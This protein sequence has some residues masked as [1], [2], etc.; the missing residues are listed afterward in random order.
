[1]V[2]FRDK[3]REVKFVRIT[4]DP[5]DHRCIH[6]QIRADQAYTVKI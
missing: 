6:V 4:L 3:Q 1:M 2:Y 5:I